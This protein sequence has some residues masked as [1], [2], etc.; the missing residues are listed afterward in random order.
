VLRP[1]AIKESLTQLESIERARA[2]RDVMA[3]MSNGVLEG[4]P[5]V[6]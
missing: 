4:E 5:V 6:L 1:D 3:V 2:I